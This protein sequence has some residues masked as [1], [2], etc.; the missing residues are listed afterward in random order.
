MWN[1]EHRT[2]DFLFMARRSQIGLYVKPLKVY[3]ISDTA[4]LN[5]I[6]LYKI[7]IK[8]SSGAK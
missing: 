8:L 4:I 2:N 3:L 6:M 5:G 1:I 7:L